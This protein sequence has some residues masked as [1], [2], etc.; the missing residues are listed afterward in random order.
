MM[1]QRQLSCTL[2][3]PSVNYCN[4]VYAGATKTVT[5]KLQR[6]LNAAARVVSDTRKFDGGLTSLLHDLHFWLDVPERV[7][8]KMGVML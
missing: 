3:L 5:N 2:L 1:D 8:Y 6:V 4:A 7:T